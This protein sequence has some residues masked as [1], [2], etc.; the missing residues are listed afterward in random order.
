MGHRSGNLPGISQVK[1]PQRGDKLWKVS[2][3]KLPFLMATD[4]KES[5]SSAS[6]MV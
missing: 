3:A 2:M 4:R 5:A 1:G 6:P